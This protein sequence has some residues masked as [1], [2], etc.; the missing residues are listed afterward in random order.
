MKKL[1]HLPFAAILLMAPLFVTPGCDA[2]SLQAPIGISDARE[3]DDLAKAQTPLRR[4]YKD[5]HD[6]WYNFVPGPG[7]MA[8]NPFPAWYPGGGTGNATHMG[9][10]STYFNQYVVFDPPNIVS[11]HAPVTM[12]FAAEL[13]AAGYTD[14][15]SDVGSIVFDKKG[16]SIWFQTL[17]NTAIPIGP[18]RVEFYGIN[19]IIGGTGKFEGATGETSLSGYFNPQDQQDASFQQEGWIEY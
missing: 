19:Q 4:P 7:W 17:S 9:K 18:T 10:V 14:I 15:P 5:L 1:F 16:N 3:G 6:T 2:D 13:A 12:F 11:L 8:P